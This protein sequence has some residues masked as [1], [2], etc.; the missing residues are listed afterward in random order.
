MDKGAWW[1]TI[2]GITESQTQLNTVIPHSRH[3]CMRGPA[4]L[5]AHLHLVFC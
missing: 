5:H 4:A 2:L 1:A 3:R